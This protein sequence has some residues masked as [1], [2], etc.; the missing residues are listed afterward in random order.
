MSRH[1]SDR[2]TG[3]WAA[4]AADTDRLLRLNNGLA[5]EKERLLKQAVSGTRYSELAIEDKRFISTLT[6]EL[7][8]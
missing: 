5:Q 7:V 3:T 6:K 1:N 8:Q 4:D 2:T